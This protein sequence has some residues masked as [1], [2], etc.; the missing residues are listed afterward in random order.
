MVVKSE[1]IYRLTSPIIILSRAEGQ[2]DCSE[3]LGDNSSPNVR[4]GWD[5]R[6]GS[7][8]KGRI[9]SGRGEKGQ[10]GPGC[11]GFPGLDSGSSGWGGQLWHFVT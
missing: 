6:A 1:V 3:A 9:S 4:G 2:E 10:A 11:W 5:T 8:R 7:F